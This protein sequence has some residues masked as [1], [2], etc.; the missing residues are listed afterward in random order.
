HFFTGLQV[1]D[2][3]LMARIRYGNL[4]SEFSRQP[5]DKKLHFFLL[6]LPIFVL[7]ERVILNLIAATY[8]IFV[9]VVAIELLS[10]FFVAFL[11]FF[12]VVHLENEH[13]ARSIACIA[14]LEQEIVVQKKKKRVGF[15]LPEDTT[16]EYF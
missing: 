7:C 4:A 13:G 15:F 6:F 9:Y 12:Q 3:M 8:A 11:A 10:I 5:W 1:P 2:F 16:K 14:E